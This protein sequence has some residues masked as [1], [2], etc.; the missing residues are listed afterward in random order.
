MASLKS[1]KSEVVVRYKIPEYY[2]ANGN[3]FRPI[4][5]Q[6]L[7]VHQQVN[8]QVIEQKPNQGNKDVLRKLGDGI[9]TSVVESPDFV[10]KII[11]SRRYGKAQ[12]IGYIFIEF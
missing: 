9:R 2:N 7:F 12:A 5:G 3:K 4:K 8:D 10:E 6:F 1:N 11:G